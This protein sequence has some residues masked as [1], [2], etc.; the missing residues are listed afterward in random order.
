MASTVAGVLPAAGSLDLRHT[1]GPLQHGR[2]DPTTRVTAAEVW[3]ATRTPDGPGTLRLWWEGD[4]LRRAAWGPGADWLLDRVPAL[5]GAGDA[6]FDLPVPDEVV[7]RALAA[8]PGLRIGR[9]DT[10]LHQ[11]VPT[12]LAQRVTSIEAARAWWLLCRRLS[13][14]APGPAGLLLPPDPDVLAQQPSWWFHP[15]G[16][17]R[18]R[19]ETVIR[20]AR[21]ARGLERLVALDP[22]EAGARL[23]TIPGVGPWTVQSVLGPVL[24]DPD[25]VPVGD[26][27]IPHSVCWAIAGEVRGSDE[28]MLELL[29][30]YAGQRGRVDPGPPAGGLV[31]AQARAA[32]AHPAHRPL[33]TEASTPGGACCSGSSALRF[34]SRRRLLFGLVGPSVLLAPIRR[35]ARS[36]RGVRWYRRPVRSPDRG[37]HRGVR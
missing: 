15:L 35:T 10:L 32:P 34:S 6:P 21:R 31:G 29:A 4:R 11:I 14:P 27:H 2:G 20:C 37:G 19:A 28:R 24:G 25:A 36:V 17:E 5:V 18:K 13:E 16:V 30:P 22:V 7:A 12:V 33:V 1:L 26:F 8:A 9:C 23:S 3:R